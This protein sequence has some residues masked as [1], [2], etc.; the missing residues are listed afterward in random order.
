M[1]FIVYTIVF[2]GGFLVGYDVR[3]AVEKLFVRFKN[4]AK[5]F[6]ADVKKDLKL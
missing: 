4:D 5:Q 1:A 6:E 3:P 2:I